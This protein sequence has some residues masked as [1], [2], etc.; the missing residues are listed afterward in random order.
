MHWQVLRF[1]T[2]WF[3]EH[4]DNTPVRVL[5]LVLWT[6]IVCIIL[7][8]LISMLPFSKW[9]VGKIKNTNSKTKTAISN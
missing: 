5:M 6:V 8:K 9:I 3:V 2:G 1:S 7:T 4:I